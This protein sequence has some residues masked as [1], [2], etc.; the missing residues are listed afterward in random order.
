MSAMARIGNGGVPRE[1]VIR[2]SPWFVNNVDCT[3][4][5]EPAA[6]NDV[7]SDEKSVVAR[8]MERRI[9][10]VNRWEGLSEGL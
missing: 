1:S 5:A 6:A 2:Y 7:R 9:A 4:P 3:E 8:V 10:L